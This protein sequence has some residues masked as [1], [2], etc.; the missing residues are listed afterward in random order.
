LE[1]AQHTYDNLKDGANAQDV[2]AVQAKIDAA[3]ARVDTMSIIAPFDGEVLYVANQPEDF[4]NT[5]SSALTMANVDHLY[6]ESQPIC[7]DID[8]IL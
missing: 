6:I 5:D 8:Q 4:V 7:S 1:D 2:A 3:Q